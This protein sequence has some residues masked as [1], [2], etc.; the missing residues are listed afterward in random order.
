MALVERMIIDGLLVNGTARV[1][2]WFSNKT[3]LIQSGYLYHSALAMILGIL[4]MATWFI[5]L[6]W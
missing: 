4:A 5:A 6:L 2:A 3:R 1:V